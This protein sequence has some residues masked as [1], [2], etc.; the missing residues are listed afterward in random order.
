VPPA[1]LPQHRP[2]L[3]DLL[4]PRIGDRGL[5]VLAVVAALL[6]LALLGSRLRPVDDG[7]DVVRERPVPFNL[8]YTEGLTPVRPQGAEVLRLEARRGP[9]FIQSFSVEPLRLPAFR[10]E[11]V[12]ALPVAAARE[13]ESL[14]A[15]FAEFEL[16]QDGKTRVNDVPGHAILF[17][18]RLGKRRLYGR[19]ILLPDPSRASRDGVRLLMLAT[20]AGGVSNALDV[21]IRGVVKRP[22]RTFRFGTERP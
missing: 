20:P 8:R 6:A 15:R 13:I 11:V 7:I 1:V 19:R 22:Y 2:T 21:G 16:V 4:G 10:G 18:A 3:R 14:R 12:G 17:R 9:R 5:L